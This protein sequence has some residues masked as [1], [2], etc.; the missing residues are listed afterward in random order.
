MNPRHVIKLK[1]RKKHTRI[2]REPGPI[3]A[4]TSKAHLTYLVS[5]D[6]LGIDT[7]N[8]DELTKEI[9][10]KCVEEGTLIQIDGSLYTPPL[11]PPLDS[12]FKR[13][14]TCALH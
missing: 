4:T 1:P 2:R 11:G 5:L 9:S 3:V 10:K 12:E 6:P 8:L 13:L 7:T 14:W